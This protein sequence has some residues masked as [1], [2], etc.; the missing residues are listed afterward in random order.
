MSGRTRIALAAVVAALTLAVAVP[1]ASAETFH[2]RGKWRDCET[3]S[4]GLSYRTEF[5]RPADYYG[6]GR[7]LIKSQIRWDKYAYGM[8]RKVDANT[9]QTEWLQINNP[10]YNFGSPHGDRTVWGHLFS[11]R[12][13]AHVIVK[14]IKNRPGPKDK[15]VET[16]ERFLEK[17]MFPD[18]CGV[19]FGSRVLPV[20]TWP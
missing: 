13:R 14:L 18:R 11:Q 6:P 10:D 15:T 9:S 16:V 2:I 3:L 17:R 20:R 7:Y 19:N 5:L 8:W 4:A 1:A 12:W